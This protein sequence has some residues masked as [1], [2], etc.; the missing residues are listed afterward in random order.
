MNVE[1]MVER[2]TDAVYPMV[3]IIN[4]NDTV[5][6]IVTTLEK[7]DMQVIVTFNGKRK[8]MCSITPSALNISQLLRTVGSIT[9]HKSAEESVYVKSI[10]DYLLNL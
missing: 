8:K 1:E 5:P 7:G 6:L 2:R 4:P 3:E 9:Y 10:E